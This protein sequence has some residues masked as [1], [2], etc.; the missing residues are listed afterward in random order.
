MSFFRKIIKI[1]HKQNFWGLVFFSSRR[2]GFEITCNSIRKK[3]ALKTIIFF[4]NLIFAF[5]STK[6]VK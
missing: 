4:K 5:L 6:I 2:D 1:V 3:T